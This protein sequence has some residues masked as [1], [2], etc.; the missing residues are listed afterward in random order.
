MNNARRLWRLRPISNSPLPNLISTRREETA[1]AKTLAHSRHDLREGGLCADCL[2][3]GGGVGVG[4]EAGQA[5]FEA[6]R[7]GDYGVDAGGWG[8]AVFD[9]G[10]D[11]GEVFV[12]L[13]DVVFFA[14]VD[15]VDDWFC[16]EEEEGV[17]CFDLLGAVA[18]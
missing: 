9:P 2:A 14:E 18:G 4:V 11:G 10:G 15:E 12:F 1:Q 17:Y 6:Y 8:C 16:G 3:F 13:A 7:D 5:L